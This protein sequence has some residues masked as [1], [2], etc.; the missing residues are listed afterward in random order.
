MDSNRIRING[1][2]IVA[3]STPVGS[4]ALGIVRLSGPDAITV[5]TKLAPKARLNERQSHS[6]HLVRICQADG[7]LLDEVVATVFR[8][9]RSFTREDVVELSCHGSP[10]ILEKVMEL[11][12]AAGARPAAPGEFT[13]RAY[14]N[15]A[16]DLAQAE[17]VAD[18]IASRSAKSHQLAVRQLQGSVSNRLSQLR[19]DL[20][21]FAA[22]LELEL[23][24]AEEDVEFANRA[25]LLNRLQICQ[26]EVSRLVASY[27]GGNAIRRGIPTVIAGKPNAG[28]SSVMNRLLDDTRV[29]VSSIPGTTRDVVEDVMILGGFEFRLMDTAG[30]RNTADMLEAE[31]IK[32]SVLKLKQASLI[33]YV[34]DAAAE[35]IQEA[36]CYMT[37]LDA[38]SDAPKL[39]IANKADLLSNELKCTDNPN[40][41]FASALTGLGISDI[42]QW[43]VDK[44]TEWD[45]EE[46][47]LT[48]QRHA[49]ALARANSSL[50]EVK[51]GLENGLGQEL[52]ALDLRIAL[53]AIGEITGHTTADDV[54]TSLFSRFCIGK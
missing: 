24:F 22:L 43:L 46:A 30:L 44:A 27:S 39:L 12:V 15:G 11:C 8:S 17:A 18:L 47:I 26:A 52:L 41:I 34:F 49:E 33:L 45:S 19:E 32:R 42:K 20:L 13:Q 10:Y 28:K 1:D 2:T 51:A 23:D 21:Q 3:I 16:L 31:G 5:A 40:V 4:G 14:L 35:S 29:I 36:E 37:S 50:D 38:P 9:P 54:L 25:Q 48:H 53:D 7:S 6:A